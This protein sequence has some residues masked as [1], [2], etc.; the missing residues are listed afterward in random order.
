MAG[1]KVPLDDITF[2]DSR[3]LWTVHNGIIHQNSRT[4]M[5][6]NSAIEIELHWIPSASFIR[7][8]DYFEVCQISQMRS[9]NTLNLT[10]MYRCSQETLPDPSAKLGMPPH[11]G[12][13]FTARN[14]VGARLCFHRHV[15]FCSQGGCQPQCM[16]GYHQPPWSRQPPGADNPPCCR[17]C[18]AIRYEVRILL[19]CNL[20]FSCNCWEKMA[21]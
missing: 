3:Q 7:V 19:E 1:E 6:S 12:P 8:F 10:M 16:L 2:E 21:K 20:V 5:S 11:P 17:A 9:E 14:E 15:W 18:W 4:K 13:I